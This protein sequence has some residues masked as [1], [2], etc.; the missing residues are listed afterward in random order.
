MHATQTGEARDHRLE[1]LVTVFMDRR[2][3]SD[4]DGL[5][6]ALR[7]PPPFGWSPS[8]KWERSDQLPHQRV[9]IR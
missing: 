9:D 4:D 2:N 5:K 1:I 6:G 7:T 3:T 8:P